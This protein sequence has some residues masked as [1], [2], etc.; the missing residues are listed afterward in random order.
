MF[1]VDFFQTL[2]GFEPFPYQIR[3]QQRDRAILNSI[4]NVPTGAGKSSCTLIDWLYDRLTRPERTPTRLFISLPMRSL[5]NQAFEDATATLSAAMGKFAEL[6]KQDIGIAK[7]MGGEVDPDWVNDCAKPQIIVCTLDQL[8]SRQ[9]LR[10]F[11]ASRWQW[12]IHAALTNNDCRIVIDETQLQGDAYQTSTV[13]Q[14][15]RNLQDTCGPVETIWMSATL[16]DKPITSRLTSCNR[17]VLEADDFAAPAADKFNRDKALHRLAGTTAG[18][19]QDLVKAIVTHHQPGTLT[20]CIVNRVSIAQEVLSG[21]AAML[22]TEPTTL[23]HSA[24]REAEKSGFSTMLRDF[25]GIV[26]ATQVIEAGIDADS[27]KLFTQVCPWASFVQRCGRAGRNGTYASCDIYWLDEGASQSDGAA[28]PYLSEDLS[29]THQ[30]LMT[31]RDASIKTLMAQPVPRQQFTAPPITSDVLEELFDNSSKA[32]GDIDFVQYIRNIDQLKVSVLWRDVPSDGPQKGWQPNHKEICGVSLGQFS[33]FCKDNAPNIWRFSFSDNDWKRIEHSTLRPGDIVLLDRQ[34]GGYSSILGW[35][36]NRAD[37]PLNLLGISLFGKRRIQPTYVK[38]EQSLEGH[39]IDV[40]AAMVAL[41]DQLSSA[42]FDNESCNFLMDAAYWHD[43]GKLHP[44]FQA[45]AGQRLGQRPKAKSTTWEKYER[46]GF[47]HELVSALMALDSG[48]DFLFAYLLAA[49]HGKVRVRLRTSDGGFING[50]AEGELVKGKALSLP[51]YPAHA[52]EWS[53]RVAQL[54][55]SHGIFSLSFLEML[56]RQ[57]DV[58]ASG[59]PCTDWQSEA[60]ELTN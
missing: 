58:M 6:A 20:L 12:P 16:D 45:A 2:T 31:L 34:A 1:Y 17:V 14:Q 19:F 36:G 22:P 37:V 4:L 51:C 33:I 7:L 13:L 48:K 52:M 11:G 25:K 15:L 30:I 47:R 38:Y 49:H 8:T 29:D 32:N 41:L 5:T 23:L 35:T 40:K 26:V 59:N 57:A 28:L 56:I 18:A 55:Q 54:C 9:L 60:G 39:S 43:Q 42:A 53:K 3:F 46:K 50:V 10:G 21:V 44:V 27:R 24:F